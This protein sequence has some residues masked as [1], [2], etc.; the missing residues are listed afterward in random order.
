[1]ANAHHTTFLRRL[2]LLVHHHFNCIAPS[3]SVVCDTMPFPFALSRG[4]LL[5]TLIM[6]CSSRPIRLLN[7]F[8]QVAIAACN[9]MSIV[10][11]R[12]VIVAHTA[13]PFELIAFASSIVALL[14]FPISFSFL[15]YKRYAE[16]SN[17]RNIATFGTLWLSNITACILLTVHAR[18]N[19]ATALCHDLSQS[20]DCTMANA[21]LAVFYMAAIFALTGSVLAHLDKH[22]GIAK[23]SPRYP[24]T[25]AASSH[26][27]AFQHPL[28]VELE[29]V[30]PEPSNKK[31]K[32]KKAH[33]QERWT[34]ITL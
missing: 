17:T 21:L 19:N 16:S 3:T 33:T 10:I 20:G 26:F 2:D 15:Y 24:I 13:G 25:K 1:M 30:Y 23:V 18:R 27:A 6:F 8:F 7:Y 28:D 4:L 31:A 29:N 5:R 32:D 14:V 11:L 22:P 34:E 9:V 12:P